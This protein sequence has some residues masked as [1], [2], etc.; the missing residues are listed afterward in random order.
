[1][2]KNYIRFDSNP[3]NQSIV[4]NLIASLDTTEFKSSVKVSRIANT[5]NDII[6]QE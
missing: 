2:M 5:S 3:S 6:F 1:M 4:E